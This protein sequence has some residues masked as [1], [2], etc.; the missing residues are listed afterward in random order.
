M[1]AEIEATQN[2]ITEPNYTQIPN[3]IFDYWMAQLTPAEFKVLLCICRKTFGW[4]KKRDRISLRQIEKMTG[5]TKPSIIKNVEKLIELN[6]VTKIKFKDEF[7]GSDAPNQYEINV[8]AA[9]G[10][11][12]EHQKNIGGS[13]LSIPPPV[14]SEYPPLV[15][16]VYT[17]KKDITKETIQKKEPPI[18]PS[19]ESSDHSI[20]LASLLFE[21]LKELNPKH[22]KPNLSSWALHIDRMIRIDNR[23]PEEIKLLIEWLPTDA[24][25]IKNI[26]STEKL[27]EKFDQLWIVM[28]KPS[29]KTSTPDKK[30]VDIEEVEK[31]R[32][33]IKR[34]TKA[35]WELIRTKGISFEDKVNHV[36]IGNDKI[37][38]NDP[39]ATEL[40]RHT[41]SKVGLTKNK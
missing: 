40:I 5:L 24:F 39:K 41:L 6:L 2:L 12:D 13:K 21:K 31:L 26:Q 1:A 10:N 23:T 20:G 27:R 25:W 15:N 34:F 18:P 30:S 29:T 8:V 19:S 9:Q 3:V 33:E 4:Q 22:K 16:S 32:A 11:L 14:Y 35:N 38:Y 36:V 37:Y 28:T 17:Q 7:D